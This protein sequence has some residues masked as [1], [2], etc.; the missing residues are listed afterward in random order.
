MYARAEARARAL[1]RGR[2][3]AGTGADSGRGRRSSPA[4]A[5]RGCRCCARAWPRAATS[6]AAARRR[7]GTLR[8]RARGRRAHGSRRAWAS[9]ATA[10]SARARSR[11][12][13][14]RSRSASAML[15]VNLDRGR[16]LLHDLP[17]KFVIVNIA[18]YTAYVVRGQDIVWSARVQVGKTYRKTPIF[19]SE[20]NYLVFNPTWTVPPGIIAATSCR[21]REARSRL[22]HAQGPQGARLERAA[23]SIPHRSTGRATRGGHIP[24]HAAPGP[25]PEER[26]R[27]RQAD[28]PESLPRVPAR[29]AVAGAVRPRRARIQLRLRARRARARARGDRARRARSSGTPRAST[30]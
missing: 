5:T 24:V 9:K 2:R 10:S 23:R 30:A 4:R 17:E 7:S 6:A 15:R 13:T 28:V 3:R 26:A 14:F 16:V 22:H 18:G 1:S 8:R 27:P 20:I 12:S 25:G 11:S 19:R 21:P 29:H